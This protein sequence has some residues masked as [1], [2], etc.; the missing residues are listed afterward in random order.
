MSFLSRFKELI[1]AEATVEDAGPIPAQ[2]T[3]I[4]AMLGQL[5]ELAA[6]GVEFREEL[7]RGGMATIEIV[8]DPALGR[9]E[10]RKVID[11]RAVDNKDHVAWFIR[12]AHVTGQLDHPNIVP[13]YDL[14]VR[15]DGLLYFTM[16]LVQGETLYERVMGLPD[17]FDPALMFELLQ[18]VVKVCEALEFA[19][20]KGVIHCDVKPQ[21][22]VLGEFGQVYLMDWGIARVLRGALAEAAVESW[23]E[24]PTA[25]TMHGTP[26]FMAAEQ[27]NGRDLDERTDV[28]GVGALLYFC[29]ARKPPFFGHSL[30]EVASQVMR[31]HKQ[32]LREAAPAGWAPPD[33]ARIVERAMAHAPADRYP[34]I[35]ALRGDLVRFMRGGGEF[36]VQA[37]PAGALLVREGDDADAAYVLL[38]GQCEV[39]TE[40][41]GHRRSLAQL[42]DGAVFG[43]T[44][45]LA[46]S[47]RT[48][49]VVTVSDCEI[50]RIDRDHFEEEVD[51]MRPWMGAFTRAL[52]R[53]F[54]EQLDLNRLSSAV[55]AKRVQAAALGALSAL[56]ARDEAGCLS[57][58]RAHLVG[59]LSALL[60]A[61]EAPI[62]GHLDACPELSRVGAT[63]RLDDADGLRARLAL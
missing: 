21:N 14:G 32:P 29:L 16:K 49:S 63:V 50:M 22:V 38:R 7:A 33:L 30:L 55:S 27:I 15:E 35:G 28:F 34:G 40:V 62:E 60:G 44:A 36:P 4:S 26:S 17:R 52:A 13:V 20:S 25:G 1:G 54:R 61:P 53:R 5:R 39:Y 45:I 48:A 47:Q 2:P 9:Q 8:H 24:S 23:V 31:G 37:V 18:V 10:A 57:L 19:H 59:H 51:R 46:A 58:D 11:P 56:G 3:P 12:E 6:R 41:G 42:R 43:E